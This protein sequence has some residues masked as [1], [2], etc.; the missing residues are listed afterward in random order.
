MLNLES[1]EWVPYSP[2]RRGLRHRFQKLLASA[3][4][5]AGTRTSLAEK[6]GV[7]KSRVT[8]L[9]NGNNITMATAQRVLDALGYDAEV[10][11]VPQSPEILGKSSLFSKPSGEI[12]FTYRRG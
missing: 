10:D 5:E 2:K 8:Q 9:L 11:L 4:D 7:T 3:V 6:L 12:V 1:V